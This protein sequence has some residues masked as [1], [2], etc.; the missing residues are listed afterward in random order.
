[1][2]I[3]ETIKYRRSVRKYTS[4]EVALE[5]IMLLLDAA[6]WA[7]TGGDVQAW[8]F[9]VLREDANIRKLRAVSPGMLGEPTAAIV[10]CTDMDRVLERGGRP[11][12]QFLPRMDTAMAAQNIMLLAQ[13]LGL[14]SC[15]IGSFNRE[16]VQVLLDLPP[17]VIPE[18]VISLGY[19]AG[20]TKAPARRAIEEIVH[21]ERYEGRPDGS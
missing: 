20:E 5:D 11:P 18:L 9:I 21:Y 1:M 6:R 13:E 8:T 17:S 19:P 12:Q 10:I 7:P 16:A 3:L 2:T 15:P 4:G 14:G